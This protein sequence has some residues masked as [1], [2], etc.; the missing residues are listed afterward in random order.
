MAPPNPIYIHPESPNF[1]AHWMKEAVSF[2]KVKLTNKSNGNGQIMLNSLHKY[3]PRVHL[4]RVGAEEQRTVRLPFLFSCFF[5][6]QITYLYRYFLCNVVFN[7]FI[8]TDANIDV[9][10]C[11]GSHVSFSRN[12]IHRSDSVSE[13]GSNEPEDQVQSFREGIPRC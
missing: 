2:A 3:E 8:Y 6:L 11:A 1:G 4:V 9:V 7:H 10:V 13:R 12:A 5:L